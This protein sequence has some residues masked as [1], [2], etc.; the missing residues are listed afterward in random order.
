MS[1]HS[2]P[3]S[4][5]APAL[6]LARLARHTHQSD[7]PVTTRERQRKH[8]RSVWLEKHVERASLFTAYPCGERLTDKAASRGPLICQSPNPYHVERMV[9]SWSVHTELVSLTVDTA[10]GKHVRH[11]KPSSFACYSRVSLS[12]LNAGCVFCH[13]SPN[14]NVDTPQQ[15]FKCLYLAYLL[16]Q[17]S[18]CTPF[19]ISA[20]YSHPLPC[21][22][23]NPYRTI[24]RPHP[25]PPIIL[26]PPQTAEWRGAQN[27][28]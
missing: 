24:P 2:Q 10:F 22:S 18:L 14:N 8:G 15:H 19:S 13:Q 5:H 17:T 12:A 11:T 28:Q 7:E 27:F 9:R 20:S 21:S 26:T 3:N 1:M 6:R 23:H 16:F 25:A 4:E